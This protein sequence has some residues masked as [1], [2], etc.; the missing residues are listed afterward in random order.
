MVY[1]NFI[2]GS[3]YD[4]HFNLVNILDLEDIGPLGD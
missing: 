4:D 1:R 3:F 2:V